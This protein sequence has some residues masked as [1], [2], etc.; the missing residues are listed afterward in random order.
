[1][2]LLPGSRRSRR[3]VSHDTGLR[4]VGLRFAGQTV[5]LLLVLLV[6]IEGSV[7][8]I[9]RHSLLA[10]LESTLRAQSHTDAG[11]I[12]QLYG[13]NSRH[14]MP[15]TGGTAP[16]GGTAPDH[17]G[18]VDDGHRGAA[19][20]SVIFLNRSLTI[21][22][23]G[24]D[25]LHVNVVDRSSARAAI[26]SGRA[27]C[28]S[29]VQ[30]SD[31]SY[32]VFTDVLRLHG[33]IVG[34]VETAIPAHQYDS[35][36]DLLQAVLIIVALV[37][38]AVSGLI[39]ALLAQR[40]LI[41]I[42]TAMQRQRQFVADAA[43]ELRTPLAIMRTTGEVGMNEPATQQATIEQ[44]LAENAHLTRLV[45]DLS[46]LARADNAAIQVESLPVDLAELTADTVSEL[47]PLAEV[48]GLS[49][50]AEADGPLFV[51]GDM[52]RLR[53]L[54]LILLDNAFKHTPEGGEVMIAVQRASGRAQ[55]QVRDTGPGI[56]PA[57][58]PRIFD[59]FYR[60]DRAR[61]GEGSGLGL[62]IGRWIVEA[63][64]GSI[65]A[66]NAMNGGAIFTVTLPL[67]R[68]SGAA[69]AATTPYSSQSGD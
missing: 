51:S 10:S 33:T 34:V 50:S 12:A 20:V 38:L 27:Q 17:D 18:D 2:K 56:A 7:Y 11:L 49:L 54:M 68:S 6:V 30:T 64:G 41:P 35:T 45:D 32:L 37:G 65:G 29:T 67:P 57:D 48:Q 22:A 46:L 1:M 47:Q 36:L 14:L 44:M 9:T 8:V 63:H 69:R 4:R 61:T 66:A 59:R 52:M 3:E 40:A 15:P 23:R 24:R 25:S 19:D 16:A 42:R 5:V 21:V 28:C 60:S 43:H 55:I 62:A 31:E 53:Q 39:S 13:P 26:L 58:L